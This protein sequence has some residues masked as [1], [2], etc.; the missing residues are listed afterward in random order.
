MS[1]EPE[2]LGVSDSTGTSPGTS[3]RLC[4]MAYAHDV[5]CGDTLSALVHP[6]CQ[7][8][9]LESPTVGSGIS[10]DLLPC[11]CKRPR[12]HAITRHHRRWRLSLRPENRRT[13]VAAR[14]AANHALLRRT[15]ASARA[16]VRVSAL[17]YAGN[18]RLWGM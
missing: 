10:P 14:P 4:P 15:D 3:A 11:C 12:A 5:A 8:I 7:A 16:A 9:P 2:R 18:V 1:P 13:A 17:R 6:D